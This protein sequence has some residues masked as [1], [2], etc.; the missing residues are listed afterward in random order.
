MAKEKSEDEEVYHSIKPKLSQVSKTQPVSTKKHYSSQKVIKTVINPE[1]VDNFA[2]TG[3]N[4]ITT[5]KNMQNIVS[6]KQFAGEKTSNSRPGSSK[7]RVIKG[8]ARQVGFTPKKQLNTKIKGGKAQ[9]TQIY[10]FNF[11]PP[12]QPAPIDFLNDNVFRQQ[13]DSYMTDS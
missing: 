13:T 8:I 2:H 6:A 9:A 1:K 12:M 11:F 10:Q 3:N 7:Y 4:V 5:S